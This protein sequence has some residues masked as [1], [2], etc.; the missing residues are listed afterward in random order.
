VVPRLKNP[1]P[2]K[3]FDHYS[4]THILIDTRE[5]QPLEFENSSLFK[6]DVGDYSV[7][8]DKFKYTFVDR[9]SFPDFC[10]SVTAAYDR[11]EREMAR[12]QEM[13]CYMFVVVEIE[14]GLIHKFNR[15]AYKKHNLG[16]VMGNM[17]KLQAKYPDCV[18]FVF[19]GS[20][21]YS[22]LLIPKL[23]C[24]GD[25]VWGSDVNYFWAQ[26]LEKQKK[27]ENHGLGGW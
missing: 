10:L 24:L 26:F 8:A 21:A 11:F 4:K 20:R 2:K 17:R 5:K 27:K 19:G 16:Y 6:L 23:L 9:K 12:C 7:E 25:E 3:F 22:A 15:A 13:G 14:Y 18:Q 1:L